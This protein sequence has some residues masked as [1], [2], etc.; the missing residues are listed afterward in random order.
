MKLLI[1]SQIFM[2]FGMMVVTSVQAHAHENF[3]E[4]R[5]SYCPAPPVVDTQSDIIIM[6]QNG[7]LLSRWV[8]VYDLHLKK[9]Y[10][11]YY[12]TNLEA[13]HIQKVANLSTALAND[14][15]NYYL[16]YSVYWLNWASSLDAQ[17]Q[18]EEY[19]K[20]M[21]AWRSQSDNKTYPAYIAYCRATENRAACPCAKYPEAKGC[22]SESRPSGLQA[23]RTQQTP[24]L[25]LTDS[26]S[27]QNADLGYSDNQ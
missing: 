5:P 3:F 16:R 6:R 18:V 7:E 8:K 15:S 27:N 10:P 13:S 14:C 9:S 22:E 1:R 12:K 23:Q 20:K 21:Q 11:R 19:Q 24:D 17:A 4:N 25:A 2:I 26:G